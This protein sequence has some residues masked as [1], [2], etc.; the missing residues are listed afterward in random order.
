MTKP[1]SPTEK[2]KWLLDAGSWYYETECGYTFTFLEDSLDEHGFIYCPFCG[3]RTEE[4]T[5][6][7]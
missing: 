4:V 5:D 2:C 3:K 6:A 1:Q 7:E